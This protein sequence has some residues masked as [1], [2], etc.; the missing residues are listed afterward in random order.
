VAELKQLIAD[1]L[2]VL[3]LDQQQQQGGGSVAA[4]PRFRTRHV[5]KKGS[6]SSG[7][8]YILS[9]GRLSVGDLLR[10]EEEI[11]AEMMMAE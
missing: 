4:P 8:S 1:E 7:I 9:N 3:L 10:N 11:L 2:E 5:R 6:A